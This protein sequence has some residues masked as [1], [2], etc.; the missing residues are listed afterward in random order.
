MSG[1]RSHADPP[2][3]HAQDVAFAVVHWAVTTGPSGWSDKIKRLVR[4]VWFQFMVTWV[5]DALFKL[6]DNG[7]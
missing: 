2:P 7:R 3:G 5:M 4:R 6:D 1:N